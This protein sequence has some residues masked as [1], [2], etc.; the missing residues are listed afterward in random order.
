MSV[1]SVQEQM[2]ALSLLGM[3]EVFETNLTLANK[4]EWSH[5]EFLSKLLQSEKSYRDDRFIEK[6][7]KGAHFKRN[8]FLVDFDMSVKRGVTKGVLQELMSLRWLENAKPIIFV[9]QTGMGKSYLAEA[10]GRYVCSHRKT[11]FFKEST[12]L[13]LMI[14][15]FL[16]IKKKFLK[17][18][19]IET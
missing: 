5:E 2:Q 10:L 6:K 11:V 7:V 4:H 3:Q 12:E 18:F 13:F 15:K 8:A 16:K 14:K 19:W 9:G 1:V 17:I